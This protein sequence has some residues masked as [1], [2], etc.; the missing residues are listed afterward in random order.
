[1][2]ELVPDPKCEDEYAQLYYSD[3]FLC[4]VL[5]ASAVSVQ[6]QVQVQEH[7]VVAVVKGAAD[8]DP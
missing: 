8:F 6:N 1:V 2:V 4:P 3:W 7:A 5:V